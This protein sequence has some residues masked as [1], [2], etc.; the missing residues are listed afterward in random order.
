MDALL[1]E[2]SGNVMDMLY[3][4]FYMCNTGSD[5]DISLPSQGSQLILVICSLLD[6]RSLVTPS[7]SFWLFKCKT[8]Q[9]KANK[10]HC[11]AQTT[12]YSVAIAFWFSRA[13]QLSASVASCSVMRETTRLGKHNRIAFNGMSK[14][15]NRKGLNIF[16]IVPFITDLFPVMIKIWFSQRT[17]HAILS[18]I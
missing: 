4:F 5:K 14:G 12:I 17:T 1:K 3:S 16:S 8:K 9:N 11:Q 7:L 6:V 10:K 15:T 2:G 13:L 18:A